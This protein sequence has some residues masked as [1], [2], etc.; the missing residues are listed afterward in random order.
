MSSLFD[1]FFEKF[2]GWS[3]LPFISDIKKFLDEEEKEKQGL[4][5]ILEGS[6]ERNNI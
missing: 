6:D 4:I 1:R 3:D 5:E 2:G